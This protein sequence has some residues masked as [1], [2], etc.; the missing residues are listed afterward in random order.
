MAYEKLIIERRPDLTVV[1]GDVNSTAAATLAAVKLGIKTAH[2]EA[3]LC[4]ID[5][6][7]ALAAQVLDHPPRTHQVPE[8]W[9]G[10]SAHRVVGSIRR[11]LSIYGTQGGHP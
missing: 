3:G 5:N 4:S 6:A 11:F 2:L 7:E 9:D 1:V 8:L 10:R